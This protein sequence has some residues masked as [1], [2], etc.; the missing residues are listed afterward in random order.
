MVD[1][2]VCLKESSDI[3]VSFIMF[4]LLYINRQNK[5]IKNCDILF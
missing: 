2:S 1:E 3:N 4:Y 5:R